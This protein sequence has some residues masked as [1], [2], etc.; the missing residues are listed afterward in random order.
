MKA[1]QFDRVGGPEVIRMVDLPIPTPKPGEVR[2]K[3]EVCG[4]NFSDIMIRQG[5][6]VME[7]PFPYRVGREFSGKIDAVGDGV[8]ALK[9]GD[10]VFGLSFNGGAM[11]EYVVVDVASVNPVP[12]GV[13]PA[14]AAA[15]QIQGINALFCV[16]DYGHVQKGETVVVHSAAGGV[17]G[18]AVQIAVARGARVIGTTSKDEKRQAILELGAEALNYTKGDWVADV[19]RLTAGRGADVIIDGIGGEVFRRS[20]FGAT[21]H[22]G[23]VIISGVSSGEEVSLTNFQISAAHRTLVGVSVPSFFP[24]RVDQLISAMSRLFILVAQ[25]LLRVRI[26]HRVPIADAAEAFRLMEERRN[27][28]KVVVCP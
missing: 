7:V 19:K 18:L 11:A 23:R 13:P 16:E 8:S 3:V 4:L 28:G 15:L 10:P 26:G 9:S 22:G 21:A 25:G 24:G 20:V 5:R 14:E 12:P 17:G 1:V 2:V 27:A 6:Y